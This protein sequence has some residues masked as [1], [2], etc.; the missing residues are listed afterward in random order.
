MPDLIVAILTPV[1]A[2]LGSYLAARVTSAKQLGYERLV[3]AADHVT[4]LLHELTGDYFQWVSQFTAHERMYTGYVIGS[5]LTMLNGYQ[6]RYRARLD[7]QTR[8]A[9]SDV[10]GQ[11]IEHHVRVSNAYP[12]S[13]HGLS[14]NVAVKDLPEDARYEDAVE[15]TR[16]WL[17]NELPR[18]LERLE[19]DFDRS[20]GSLEGSWWRRIFGN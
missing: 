17:N 14:M 1:G 18:A 5:K 15:E 10:I 7:N 19:R 12:G 3:E 11:L 8:E 16:A 13:F 20:L 2:V 6:N 4:P 9:L